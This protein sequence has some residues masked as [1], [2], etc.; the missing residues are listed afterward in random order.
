MIARYLLIQ[1]LVRMDKKGA[2]ANNPIAL[3]PS[4]RKITQ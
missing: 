4:N 3:A 2:N 1:V